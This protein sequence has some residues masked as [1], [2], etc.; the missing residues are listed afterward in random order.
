MRLSDIL[1][2][3]RVTTTLA[4]A[5]KPETLRALSEL[6]PGLA[7][8]E[9]HRVLLERESL[10]STAVGSGVAIPH[11]RIGNI[12]SIQ[13]ALAIC[14]EGID[15]DAVDG[16]PA[17]IFVVVLAPERNTPEHLRTLA[18]ISRVLREPAVRRAVLEAAGP[19]EALA[20]ILDADQATQLG[21]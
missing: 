1:S 8:E 7:A 13:A 10:A 18:R 11:G 9:V 12:D 20:A 17:R 3:R 5:G 2:H 15:F 4:A 16:Q 19:T 6:F 21:A 14:R